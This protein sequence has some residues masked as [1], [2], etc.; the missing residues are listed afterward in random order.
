[1]SPDCG[2]FRGKFRPD[3]GVHPGGKEVERNDG[4]PREQLLDEGASSRPCRR[5]GGPVNTMKQ[6]RRRDGGEGNLLRGVGG[7]DTI[8]VE[9]AT[10]RRDQNARVDQRRHG[11][12]GSLGWL[13]VIAASAFQ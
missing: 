11:D 13:R 8:P 5:G 10:L 12:F 2:A 7:H 4:Q 3:A 9:S 6:L 1:M